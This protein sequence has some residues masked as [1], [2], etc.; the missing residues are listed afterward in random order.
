M[1]LWVAHPL[2]SLVKRCEARYVLASCLTSDYMAAIITTDEGLGLGAERVF[3]KHWLA[4]HTC[5]GNDPLAVIRL[6]GWRSLHRNT[7]GSMFPAGCGTD[8]RSVQVSFHGDLTLLGRNG[9]CGPPYCTTCPLRQSGSYIVL[10]TACG[11]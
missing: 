9:A 5:R 2:D 4:R 10:A 1:S 11:T 6:P 7:E 8:E 3:K